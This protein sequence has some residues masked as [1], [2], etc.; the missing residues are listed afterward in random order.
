[1]MSKRL[2]WAK[3]TKEHVMRKNGTT[4]I[5]GGPP[6]RLSGNIKRQTGKAIL[7]VYD[8][9]E[10]W[11]PKSVVDIDNLGEGSAVVSIPEWLAIRHG[12]V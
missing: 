1:M 8:E 11:L 10:M 4:V 6:I 12:L 7:F 9:Q 2:N 5:E 3:L